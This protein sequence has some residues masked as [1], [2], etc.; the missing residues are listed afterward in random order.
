MPNMILRMILLSVFLLSMIPGQSYGMSSEEHGLISRNALLV[1]VE[2]ARKTGLIN[3][4]EAKSLR[5]CFTQNDDMNY[6]R[7]SEIVDDVT[8]PSKFMKLYGPEADACH[9]MD[10]AGARAMLKARKVTLINRLMASKYNEDHFQEKTLTKFREFNDLAQLYALRGNL[11]W[12]LVVNAFAA[13]YLEDF[14]AP[15]HVLT[16]RTEVN[17]ISAR[18]LHDI[19]DKEGAKISVKM[20]PELMGYLDVIKEMK[21]LN[22]DTEQGVNALLALDGRYMT[23]YGDGLIKNSTGQKELMIAE[24]AK[25]VTAVIRAY[26]TRELTRFDSDYVVQINSEKKST[27]LGEIDYHYEEITPRFDDVAYKP[28]RR[29]YELGRLVPIVELS[30]YLSTPMK[31]GVNSRWG[32]E[33]DLAVYGIPRLTDDSAA[34]KFFETF[35]VGAA[36]GYDYTDEIFNSTNYSHGP[37]LKLI[38]DL[39]NT[40]IGF[41]LYAKWK[42]NHENDHNFQSF[43]FGGRVT[44]SR[45]FFALYAGIGNEPRYTD[46]QENIATVYV[47]LTLYFPVGMTLFE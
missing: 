20:T 31:S 7:L 27:M 18:A 32:L 36:L 13:H 22:G 29:D 30:P 41:C 8:D 34:K 17:N 4:D 33:A 25:T 43:P 38:F 12:A 42:F 39:K 14:F 2:Y 24:V 35:L 3:E 11:A 44:F 21:Q 16:P 10:C 37:M 40:D 19:L 47:G 46:K 6:G 28:Y 45:D 9:G 5:A 26:K 23:V 1:S 15:G